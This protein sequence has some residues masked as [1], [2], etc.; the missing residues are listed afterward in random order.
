M[1]AVAE[2]CRLR[3][4]RVIGI[5]LPGAQAEPLGVKSRGTREPVS[6]KRPPPA[7]SSA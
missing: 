7:R 1:V 2:M 4:E 3:P 5:V 6:V